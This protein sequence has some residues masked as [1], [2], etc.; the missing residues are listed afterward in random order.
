MFVFTLS[1]FDFSVFPIDFIN[2]PGHLSRR[3]LLESRIPLL[4]LS[5]TLL[6]LC[7]HE[8]IVTFKQ[9]YLMIQIV[10]FLS[11]FGFSLDGGRRRV[12]QVE[13][14]VLGGL[15]GDQGLQVGLVGVG[16]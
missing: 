8:A 2:S 10:V 13:G 3:L 4:M 6:E 14:R 12:S 9:L 11:W 5:L 15:R 1:L 7:T 16:R